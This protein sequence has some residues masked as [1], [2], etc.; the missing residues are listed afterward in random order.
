MISLLLLLD[1]FGVCGGRHFI[2]TDPPL[3]VIPIIMPGV[4]SAVRPACG[5]FPLLSSFLPRGE[6]FEGVKTFSVRP[7][8]FL[9]DIFFFALSPHYTFFE[10]K[11]ISR[12]CCWVDSD[13]LS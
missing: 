10:L 12:I 1:P 11:L 2:L 4:P 5:G 9:V 6:G 7:A 8:S 3:A 13:P